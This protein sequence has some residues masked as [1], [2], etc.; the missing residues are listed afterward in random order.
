MLVERD[1]NWVV[2]LDMIKFRHLKHLL[3][4]VCFYY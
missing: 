4:I 2:L 3:E 1:F